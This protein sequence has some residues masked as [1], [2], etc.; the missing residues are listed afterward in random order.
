MQ[1]TLTQRPTH[2]LGYT[3]GFT[4]SHALDMDTNGERGGPN[5]TPYNFASDYSNSG[6]DIRKRFTATITYDLP[7]KKG[8]AHLLEGWKLTS[9]VTVQNGLPWG[10]AGDSGTDVSGQAEN[11][12]RWNFSG[13]PHDFSA[14]GKASIPFFAGA[15]NP[16]CVA[17][18]VSMATLTTYGCYVVGNSVMTPPAYG[19]Y[20]NLRR[21][22][23]F[24]NTFSVWDGSIIKDTKIGE[25]ISAEFRFEMFNVL[26]HTNFGNP[27]FNGG[28]GTDP[29]TPSSGFGNSNNTPDVANNNPALGSGGPREFQLGLRL[30]F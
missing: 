21:N 3:L 22:F 29:F 4:W 8:F 20:G 17:K 18:A 10:A 26:N 1:A 7:S 15:S 14:F 6:F 11:V 19:T 25:R 28:G 5:N 23:F 13:N 27:S 16:A 24:G 9:I 30:S 2:G 12:D